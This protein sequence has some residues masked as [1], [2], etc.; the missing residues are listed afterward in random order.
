MV[1]VSKLGHIDAKNCSHWCD[2]KNY[3][4]LKKWCNGFKDF[5]I[6][7]EDEGYKSSHLQLN[8]M[9]LPSLAWA[10]VNPK[11]KILI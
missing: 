5:G 1:R 10:S 2:D 3:H 11:I 6:Q 9:C 8:W 4:L 7:Y